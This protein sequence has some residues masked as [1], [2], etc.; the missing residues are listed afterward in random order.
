MKKRKGNESDTTDEGLLSRLRQLLSA[1]VFHTDRS[2]HEQHLFV[3]T[4]RRQSVPMLKSVLVTIGLLVLATWPTDFILFRDRIVYWAFVWRSAAVTFAITVWWAL[5]SSK[6]ARQN[7]NVL[8]LSTAT[9]LV[10][11]AGYSLGKAA[12]LS[13]MNSILTPWLDIA[14]LIPLLTTLLSIR[15]VSRFLSTLIITS[16]YLI[17]YL[18]T[19]PASSWR[20]PYLVSAL[21]TAGTSV[22]MCTFLG[23]AIYHLNRRDYFRE[24]A[25]EKER[26]TI[27]EMA[28]HDQLTGLSNYRSFHSTFEREFDRAERYD[29]RITLMMMDLDHFKSINDNYGHLVGDRVLGEVGDII[30]NNIRTSDFA[31]R[32]GGEEFTILLPETSLKKSVELAERLRRRLKQTTFT[33]GTKTFT[34]TCSIG[35]AEYDQSMEE[36][37]DLIRDA[38]AALYEAK[39]AGRD[40]TRKGSGKG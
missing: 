24:R 9:V 2:T 29:N 11:I 25:L 13:Q 34:V 4:I 14:Y 28:T 16:C 31:A 3:V 37:E 40:R 22:V 7:V 21:I 30:E 26:Q 32:Y 38:D 19:F 8:F 20:N 1:Y 36:P 17:G 5:N 35:V 18:S 12:Q 27:E 10:T 6:T 33:A 39:Q 15:V 23:H